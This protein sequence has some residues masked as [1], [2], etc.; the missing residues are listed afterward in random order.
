MPKAWQLF[1]WPGRN[2]K[3]NSAPISERG[4]INWIWE[5]ITQIHNFGAVPNI[6]C[7]S[8][9]GDRIIS[10]KDRASPCKGESHR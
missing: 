2:F 1:S 7:H 5:E 10:C 4:N 6:G 9:Q 8:E 3:N